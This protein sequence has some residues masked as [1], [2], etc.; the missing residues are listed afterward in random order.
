MIQMLLSETLEE[1]G[2][3]VCAVAGTEDD[4]VAQAARHHPGLMIVDLNLDD[5]NGISAMERILK[6]GPMP[7]VFI[8]GAPQRIGQSGAGVLRKPFSEDD[9]RRAIYNI[10]GSAA[11]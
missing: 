2:Y 9:L 3:D 8:S 1:M 7:C 6:L 5:G 4:A 10:L 11:G